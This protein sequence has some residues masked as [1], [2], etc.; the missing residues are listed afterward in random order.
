VSIFSE[1]YPPKLQDVV[2]HAER[3]CVLL[4]DVWVAGDDARVWLVGRQEEVELVVRCLV[5]DWRAGIVDE[6]AA[7][8][9]VGAYLR[10]LHIAAR[11]VLE[12]ADAFACCSDGGAVTLPPV[13]LGAA[14]RCLPAFRPMDAPRATDTIAVSSAEAMAEW[15]ARGDGGVAVGDGQE[16]GGASS[17]RGAGT[18]RSEDEDCVSRAAASVAGSEG[19]GGRGSS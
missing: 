5:E 1:Q 9:S 16:P 2:K 11:G 6:A 14:T 7:A 13:D 3:F 8:S 10:A 15:L 4:G 17:P 12:A 19:C 18:A